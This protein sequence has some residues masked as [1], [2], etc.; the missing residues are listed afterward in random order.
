M[1]R[2]CA[3]LAWSF[4]ALLGLRAGAEEDQ[5]C[6]GPIV[7]RRE[8]KAP[9]SECHEQLTLPVLYVVVSHTA[10][11]SCNTP[12]LCLQQAHNVHHYHARTLGFCDVGYK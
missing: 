3:L 7:P 10:G 6:C 2:L 12:A 8:W 5:T 9:A 1:S 11:S 4:L